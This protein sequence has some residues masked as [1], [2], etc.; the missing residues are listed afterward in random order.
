MG[1]TPVEAASHPE[2]FY[3]MYQFFNDG[4]APQKT[5]ILSSESEDIELAGMVI[6][7][8]TNLTPRNH[9]VEMGDICFGC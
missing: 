7:F 9:T 4:E 8:I 6:N 5:D 2:A 3:H 1:T